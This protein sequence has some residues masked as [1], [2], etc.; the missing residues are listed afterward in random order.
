VSSGESSLS[1]IIP[2]KNEARAI[3]DI[4]SRV[5]REFPTAEIIVVDDGSTDGTGKIAADAS[6]KVI[7]HP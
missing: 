2:A 4:V 3:G 5:R 7:R 6:A 1:V